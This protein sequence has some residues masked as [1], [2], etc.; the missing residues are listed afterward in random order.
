MD[1][2]YFIW[3]ILVY[4]EKLGIDIRM[5]NRIGEVIEAS[6]SEITAQCYGLYELP[7]FGS[8]V[9]TRGTTGDIYGIVYNATTASIEPGRRPIARGKDESSE[10]AI[11]QSSP[12]LMKLFRSEFKALIV[13]YQEND[14]IY[15]LLPPQPAHLHNFVYQCLPHEVKE[16]SQSFFFLSLLINSQPSIP[17]TELITAVLRSMS[18]LQEDKR[19]F[20]VAAG[21]ELS[22]IFCGQYQRLKLVLERLQI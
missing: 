12:Q 11:Y 20:L 2:L 8:L 21:K 4:S 6:T 13:G 10:E 3:I 9:K 18:Q 16:F 5:D 17:S 7:P 14:K 15:Q 19:S 22:N 1:V